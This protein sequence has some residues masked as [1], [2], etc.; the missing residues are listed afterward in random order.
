MC[1]GVAMFLMGKSKASTSETSVTG[2]SQILGMLLLFISLCF[3]G[4]V[5]AY[6]DLL[7]AEYHIGPFDLMLN[8]YLGKFIVSGFLLIVFGQVSYFFRLCHEQGFLL[9]LLGFTGAF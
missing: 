7:M 9:L 8:L 4:G 2:A 5:G 6:E 3:D 1:V